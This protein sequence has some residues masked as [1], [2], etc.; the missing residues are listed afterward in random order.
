MVNLTINDE[1]QMKIL[2]FLGTTEKMISDVISQLSNCKK[3]AKIYAMSDLGLS[4]DAVR[5]MG[6]F[7]VGTCITWDC[8]VPFV[9]IDATVNVC[10]VCAYKLKDKITPEEFKNRI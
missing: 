4:I 8:D 3:D 9:P 2:E 6:G 10:G 5:M 7:F 1:T